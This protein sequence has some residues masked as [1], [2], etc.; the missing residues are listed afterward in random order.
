MFLLWC[1][2]KEELERF[3]KICN[4]PPKPDAICRHC[5]GQEFIYFTDP[6][7]KVRAYAL[8]LLFGVHAAFQHKIS[9]SLGCLGDRSIQQ[10]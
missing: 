2:L 1:S 3:I 5:L 10:P 7:F 4:F 9:A 8:W 6:D